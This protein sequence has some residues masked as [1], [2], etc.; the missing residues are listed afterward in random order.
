MSALTPDSQPL[1]QRAA[2][3]TSRVAALLGEPELGSADLHDLI[4]RLGNGW[5]SSGSTPR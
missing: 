1:Q 4:V 5:S 2:E 3:A